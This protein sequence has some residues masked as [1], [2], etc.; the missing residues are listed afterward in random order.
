[1]KKNKGIKKLAVA[2]GCILLGGGIIL[3]GIKF[4]GNDLYFPS[5]AATGKSGAENTFPDNGS[6]TRLDI[7]IAAGD[8]QILGDSDLKELE[9]D[10][11]SEN[12]VCE[13]RDG[14]LTIKDN[15]DK[16]SGK[17]W[18]QF[19]LFKTFFKTSRDGQLILKVP[20]KMLDVLTVRNDFGK[21]D[22]SNLE[23]D[24]LTINS[25]GGDITMKN[26]AAASSLE[27]VQSM[28]A[29]TMEGCQGGDLKVE[30]GAGSTE[31]YE[32]RFSEGQIYGSTGDI[33]IDDSSFSTLHVEN[34]IG[35]NTLDNVSAEASVYCSA[36]IGNIE[37]R[38]LDSSNIVLL[39]DTGN[40][41]GSVA[42][43]REDYQIRADVNT[44]NSNLSDQENGADKFLDV[45]VGMGNIKLKFSSSNK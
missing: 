21:L 36:D 31:I 33:A 20:E 13:V 19:F 8:I 25:S 40:I 18:Y 10:N 15:E 27:I 32:G 23:T 7:S 1:M 38:S 34:N 37:I 35:A 2:A 6:V 44:G 45:H 43:A 29:V 41:E 16:K 17:K 4:A 24:T 11:D 5:F 42:G 3:L 39:A 12:Y 30:N 14:V 22:I 9:V 26:V 28:G